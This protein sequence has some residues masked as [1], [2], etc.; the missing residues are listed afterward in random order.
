MVLAGTCFLIA[1]GGM[2]HAQGRDS[3]RYL[4]EAFTRVTDNANIAKQVVGYGYNEGISILGGWVDQGNHLR[5][6]L[7][8]KGGTSYLFLGA[9]DKDAEDVDLEILNENGKVLAADVRVAAD[10]AVEFTPQVDGAY[11]LK[12]T[13]FRSNQKAPCVCVATILKKNGWN[14]PLR[15]LDDSVGKLIKALDVADRELQ[16]N[17]GKRFDL[18]RANNQ[19]AVFGGVLKQGETV[20]VN[21]IDLGKG[22]RGFIAV[23]DRD[24][25]DVDL[26]LLDRKGGTLVEDTSTNPS[27]SF[28]HEPNANDG[29]HGL[30]IR[31]YRSNGP[32]V[33]MMSIFDV[34]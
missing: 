30:K 33:V 11:T 26:Y 32:A 34:R 12:L 28:V 21:N 16:K 4:S 17:A 25:Q 5:F 22:Q 20:T 1:G 23:G 19:W 8:L 6:T 18:R 31:N 13:L 24:A 7:P 14:I 2:A 10:A 27:A 29:P 3:G 15:D 9:G